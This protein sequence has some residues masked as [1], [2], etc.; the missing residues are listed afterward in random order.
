MADDQR[1]PGE[2]PRR[3][4]GGPALAVA[5]SPTGRPATVAPP[6]PPGGR[7]SFSTFE[8]LNERDYRWYFISMIGQNMA[9][10]VNMLARSFLAFELTGSFAALG[11]M[12]LASA[13]PMLLFSPLGG[14]L[15]DRLPKRHVLQ[16]GQAADLIGAFAVGVLLAADLLRF[17]HL[18]VAGIVHGLAVALMMPAVQAI[19]PETVGEQRTMNAVALGAASMNATRMVAPAAAGFLLAT[20]GWEWVYFLISGAYVLAIVALLPVPVVQPTAFTPSTDRPL[21]STR[22]L[23][24]KS[25]EDMLDGARYIFMHPIVLTLM[26]THL[27]VSMLSMPYQFLLPGFV[28]NVLD[29]GPELLGLLMSIA[30]VGSLAGSLVIASLP[31]KRRGLLFIGGLMVLGLSLLGF[32]VSNVFWL[33]ALASLWIGVGQTSRM[34]LTSVLILAH[35]E[36]T[37]R[38]RVMGVYMMEFGLVSFGTFGIAIVAGA[39]GV[40]WA[41]AGTALG[42]IA[43]TIVLFAF[44]PRLRTLD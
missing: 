8:S 21:G 33:A 11:L 14:V 27:F 5:P 20:V 9:L 29:A 44:V 37:Y 15:A 1:V 6:P 16:A 39:V 36:A 7:F 40:Q 24:G 38:G 17:E 41:F 34:S 22:R 26:A 30:A 18:F 23:G 35:V 3:A 32:A 19:I 4:T 2:G 10:N 28:S 31:S 43:L 13:I 42:L 12:S 25:V